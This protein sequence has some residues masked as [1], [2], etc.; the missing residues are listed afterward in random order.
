MNSWSVWMASELAR[1][2]RAAADAVG[3]REQEAGVPVGRLGGSH[4][5]ERR[6]R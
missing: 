5:A 3:D 4:D 6:Q 2:P 1:S